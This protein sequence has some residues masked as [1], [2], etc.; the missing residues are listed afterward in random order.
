[1]SKDGGR[2]K[3][4]PI[5]RGR[6]IIVKSGEKRVEGHGS[7]RKQARPSKQNGEGKPAEKN[8]ERRAEDGNRDKEE[9]LKVDRL[10]ESK[11]QWP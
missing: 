3:R 7:S 11:E 5:G 8:G 9:R 1:M 10:S 4:S 2:W 6:K